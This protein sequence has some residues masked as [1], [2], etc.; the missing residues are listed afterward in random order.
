M[1]FTTG[2]RLHRVLVVTGERGLTAERRDDDNARAYDVPVGVDFHSQVHLG[3]RNVREV[4]DRRRLRSTEAEQTQHNTS[5]SCVR[6]IHDK[7]SKNFAATGRVAGADL[8]R[9]KVNVT[10]HSRQQCNRLYQSRWRC[11]C[12]FCF[13]HRSSDSQCFSMCRTTPKN[14]TFTR[15]IH[16]NGSSI[17]W[18][19]FA[20]LTNVTNRETDTQ[21]VD[22]TSSVAISHI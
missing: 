5:N 9:G 10:P 2:D 21:I 15:V 11:Y 4:W 7:K 22:A 3:G 13:V 6:N 1:S 16:P 14:C 19:V 17:R 12:I 20:G 18:S 8:S